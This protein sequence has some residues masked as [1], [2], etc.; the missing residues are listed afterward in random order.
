[1]DAIS[2]TPISTVCNVAGFFA[3]AYRRSHVTNTVGTRHGSLN[4]FAGISMQE[5][6][7]SLGLTEVS[8]ANDVKRAH[9]G[10]ALNSRALNAIVGN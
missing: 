3:V 9:Y 4:G 5:Q 10:K 8:A 1:M 2:F 6:D 7:S